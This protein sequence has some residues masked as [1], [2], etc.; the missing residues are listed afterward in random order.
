M[1][2]KTNSKIKNTNKLTANPSNNSVD[3][4][5]K[6]NKSKLSKKYRN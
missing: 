3:K 2:E 4:Q 1:E 5:I 6:N